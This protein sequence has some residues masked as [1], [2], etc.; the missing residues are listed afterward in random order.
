VTL[1]PALFASALALNLLTDQAYA[2]TI[3]RFDDGTAVSPADY[4]EV[5]ATRR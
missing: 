3:A 1:G 4:L 2:A 5:V